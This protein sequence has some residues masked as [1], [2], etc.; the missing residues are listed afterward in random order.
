M[1]AEDVA[2][3]AQAEL[4]DQAN[5]EKRDVLANAW[6]RR[7]SLDME[8]TAEQLA[9]EQATVLPELARI[10]DEKF[11][12]SAEFMERLEKAEARDREQAERLAKVGKSGEFD[13]L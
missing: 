3:Q 13:G 9:Q 10:D 6:V 8:M 1:S 11:T 12:Q 2:K 5:R 4:N 7:Q